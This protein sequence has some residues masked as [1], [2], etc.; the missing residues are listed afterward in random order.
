[1]DCITIYEE[2]IRSNRNT[3]ILSE[4]DHAI[5]VKIKHFYYKTY[6]KENGTNIFCSSVKLKEIRCRALK[7]NIDIDIEKYLIEEDNSE[8]TLIN[9]YNFTKNKSLE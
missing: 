8:I 9:K 5:G 7:S 6:K 4:L 2:F 3:L 1:M